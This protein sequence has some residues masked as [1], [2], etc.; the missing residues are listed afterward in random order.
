MSK[1]FWE[2][3]WEKN[4]TSWDLG[5]VSPPI[6]AYI[7]Q[8]TNLSLRILIPGC[9]N[10]YEAE[11]LWKKGF[12]NVFIV[13][14]SDRAI[15]EFKERCPFFPEGNIIAGDFFTLNESYDLVIEQTFFCALEPDQRNNYAKK[16]AELLNNG[17]K[18][19]GVMF[20]RTFDGGP[21]YG[22]NTEEYRT[23]FSQ[24]FKSIYMAPCYNSVG[25]RLGSEIF[26]KLQVDEG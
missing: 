26:I 15:Q 1:E 16:M 3:L 21:P 18:L 19:V 2:S 13:E 20:N 23:I 12:K 25:P 6:K 24:N 9:G 7:D 22:G 17:G 8:L 10:A 5:I 11:Y 4:Q 14:I